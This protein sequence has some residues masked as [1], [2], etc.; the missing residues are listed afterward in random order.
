MLAALVRILRLLAGT[1]L[2]D[3]ALL[4]TL[5]RLSALGLSAMELCQRTGIPLQVHMAADEPLPMKTS[6]SRTG[7]RKRQTAGRRDRGFGKK[8]ITGPFP[9]KLYSRPYWKSGAPGRPSRPLR[10]ELGLT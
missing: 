9:S 8:A 6:C 10:Q 1:L 5:M 3:P 4:A 7:L 2:A